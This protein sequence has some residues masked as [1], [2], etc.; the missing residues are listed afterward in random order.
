MGILGSF[1]TYILRV[2]ASSI[3]RK[4]AFSYLTLSTAKVA[5]AVWCRCFLSLLSSAVSL[6]PEV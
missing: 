1:L 3:Y 5:I 6:P 4:Y 2:V